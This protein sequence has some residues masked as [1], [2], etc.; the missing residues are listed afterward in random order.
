MLFGCTGICRVCVGYLFLP[1]FY[2]FLLLL[3]ISRDALKLELLLAL[4]ILSY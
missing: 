1:L 3:L 4:T 2:V